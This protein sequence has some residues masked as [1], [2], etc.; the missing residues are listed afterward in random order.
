[1]LNEVKHPA[2]APQIL[3]PQGT[4]NDIIY[5]F[6]PMTKHYYCAGYFTVQP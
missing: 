1:M 2:T 6:L 5:H 4:Q 3:R